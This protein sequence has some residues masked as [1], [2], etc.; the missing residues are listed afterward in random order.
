MQKNFSFMEILLEKTESPSFS[1]NLPK[2]GRQLLLLKKA[3]IDVVSFPEKSK[4]KKSKI[5]NCLRLS[6][7]LINRL[8][9]LMPE[10]AAHGQ[11]TGKVISELK[12]FIFFLEKQSGRWFDYDC[13]TPVPMQLDLKKEINNTKGEIGKGLKKRNINPPLREV[14]LEPLERFINKKCVRLYRFFYLRKFISWINEFIHRNPV[15]SDAECQLIKRINGTLPFTRINGV[16][17]YNKEDIDA[18]LEKNM[19]RQDSS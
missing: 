12:G 17:Y 10:T 19:I 6:S 15:F 11:T 1:L 3:V 18:I 2:F 14:V 9:K 8:F 4:N 7:L 13:F 16:I 5:S